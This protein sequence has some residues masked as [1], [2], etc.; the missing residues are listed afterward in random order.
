VLTDL[1]T[2]GGRSGATGLNNH[3][4]VVGFSFT[5]T[6]EVHGFLWDGTMH[7]LGADF[8]PSHIN[9]AGQMIG[10]TAS[11]QGVFRSGNISTPI[12]CSPS[13]LNNRG[14]VVGSWHNPPP[15][16]VFRE[17]SACLWENGV[18]RELVSEPNPE[19]MADDLYSYAHDINDQGV[20]VGVSGHSEYCGSGAFVTSGGLGGAGE[21]SV[22]NAINEAGVVVGQ[23]SEEPCNEET[24]TEPPLYP[25]VWKDGTET[26]L[27]E[28]EGTARD[29]N[30]RGQILGIIYRE[31]ASPFVLWTPSAAIGRTGM[32]GN[33]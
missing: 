1:G 19:L 13:G 21:F 10:H 29:I 32:A 12:A 9:D 30:D 16:A 14:Q 15:E 4:A 27:S 8:I 31:D 20:A 18:V 5:A 28:N 7:D 24:G 23:S 11:G 26:K 3:D 22:A 6:G 17:T 25:V 33:H 2:L